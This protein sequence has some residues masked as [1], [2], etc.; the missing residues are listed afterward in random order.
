MYRSP[1][2]I[3]PPATGPGHQCPWGTQQL[4]PTTKHKAQEHRK[5]WKILK[6]KGLWH[7]HTPTYILETIQAKTLQILTFKS[8]SKMHFKCN[9][10][11]FMC[12]WCHYHLLPTELRHRACFHVGTARE[13]TPHMPRHRQVTLPNYSPRQHSKNQGLQTLGWQ[14]SHL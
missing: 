11:F 5:K 1:A 10:C 13:E 3:Q 8:I 9:L 14:V 6:W 12:L 7:T 2:E 4:L